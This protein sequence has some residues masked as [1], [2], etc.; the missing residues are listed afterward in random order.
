MESS[1]SFPYHKN[2]EDLKG[3]NK[4]PK[5]LPDEVCVG[6]GDEKI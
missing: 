4:R 1:G 2:P 3:G 5:K 6:G